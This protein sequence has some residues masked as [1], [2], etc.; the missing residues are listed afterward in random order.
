MFKT[1]IVPQVGLEPTCLTTYAPKAYVSTIPPSGYN[2]IRQAFYSQL[3]GIV[4]NLAHLTAVW[5]PEDM[6]FKIEDTL[7]RNHISSSPK[8]ELV[9]FT[10]AIYI[11]LL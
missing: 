10:G 6:I 4:S 11:N 2:H 9:S 7:K 5:V 8:E 1:P 3:R